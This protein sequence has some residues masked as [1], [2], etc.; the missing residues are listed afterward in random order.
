[1]LN[2]HRARVQMI[3]AWATHDADI[4]HQFVNVVREHGADPLRPTVLHVGCGANAPMSLLLH[5]SGATV[6]GLDA[7]VGH[8]WGLG[9]KPARYAAY[10]REVGLAKTLRKALG[11]IVYDWRYYAT[12]SAKT[13]ITLTET[14]L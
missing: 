14:G 10:A 11:E 7:S 6:T 3:E 8:R 5:S 12:L 4:F 9:I 2:S 13:G 1:M